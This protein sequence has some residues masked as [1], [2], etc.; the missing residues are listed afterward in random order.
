MK[1]SVLTTTL[2]LTDIPPAVEAG[3][4]AGAVQ[5]DLFGKSVVLN[6]VSLE[7]FGE[8]VIVTLVSSTT[9]QPLI[10]LD[11]PKKK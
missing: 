1:L 2:S 10:V 5:L 4:F 8:K 9:S 11:T 7:R 6:V 3:L